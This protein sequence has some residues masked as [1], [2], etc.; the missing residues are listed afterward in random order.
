MVYFWGAKAAQSALSSSEGIALSVH[1][2]LVSVE[3]SSGSSCVTILEQ[4]P[5][6]QCDINALYC[7]IIPN[8]QAENDESKIH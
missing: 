6:Y 5:L 3:V 8:H 4:K 7:K 1:V 2:D